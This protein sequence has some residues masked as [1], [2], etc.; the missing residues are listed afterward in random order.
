MFYILVEEHSHATEHCCRF[1]TISCL[2]NEDMIALV[3]DEITTGKSALNFI[4]AI[5]KRYP[6]KSYAVLSLLDWRSTAEKQK[7]AEAE[8]DLGIRIHMVSLVSGSITVEGQPIMDNL[9]K[10]LPPVARTGTG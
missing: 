1:L 8:A 7:F 6:R 3:D 5:Q 4:R 10:I 2:E 9:P